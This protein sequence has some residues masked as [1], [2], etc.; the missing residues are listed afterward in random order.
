MDAWDEEQVVTAEL[1][2]LYVEVPA[3]LQLAGGEVGKVIALGGSSG[4]ADVVIQRREQAGP[5]RAGHAEAEDVSDVVGALVGAQVL[6]VALQQGAEGERRHLDV[7]A[8]R[9]LDLP[10]LV[11]QSEVVALAVDEEDRHGLAGVAHRVEG[12]ACRGSRHR[13][14]GGGEEGATSEAGQS[15]GAESGT[16]GAGPGEEAPPIEVV[17]ALDFHMSPFCWN[18]SKMRCGSSCRCDVAQPTSSRLPKPGSS[19]SGAIIPSSITGW[20]RLSA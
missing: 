14:V 2:S 15:D 19:E 9:L 17:G 18:E 12:A 20:T 6:I 10:E 13:R 4:I 8:H 3:V 16:E 1:P 11:A 7:D 5:D